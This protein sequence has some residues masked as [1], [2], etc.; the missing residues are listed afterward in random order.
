M[1]F[2]PMSG[3]FNRIPGMVQGPGGAG[4][5]GTFTN[6]R[7][8]NL[9]SG[10]QEQIQQQLM[11]SMSGWRE[12]IGS[13]GLQIDP[14]DYSAPWGERGPGGMRPQ[15]PKM[16]PPDGKGG[17]I[18]MRP[19]QINPAH[20][21]TSDRQL[22]P[23]FGGPYQ[24]REQ[25]LP[26]LRDDGQAPNRGTLGQLDSTQDQSW[27]QKLL[28]GLRGTRNRGLFGDQDYDVVDQ[29]PSFGGMRPQTFD[30]RPPPTA[31]SDYFPTPAV[32]QQ[33][34]PPQIPQTTPSSMRSLPP[35]FGQQKQATP[36]IPQ[37]NPRNARMG[38]RRM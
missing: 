22:P 28:K 26:G 6:S 1:A 34:T 10:M 2:N 11:D 12:K 27:I 24:G 3:Q 20:M 16:A 33:A 30:L 15:P 31:P 32:P 13:T 38:G 14:Q 21:R 17:Y 5:F 36:Q 25:P 9:P 19:Q 7:D 23:G 8:F 29:V 37:L 35:G 4:S 18:G